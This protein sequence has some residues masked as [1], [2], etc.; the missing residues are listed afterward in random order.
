[1]KVGSRYSPLTTNS[2]CKLPKAT[3]L[4]E[5]PHSNNGGEESTDSVCGKNDIHNLPGGSVA[6]GNPCIPDLPV[7]VEMLLA[8]T[9]QLTCQAYVLVG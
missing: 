3:G 2:V 8:G 4:R 9:R 6:K 1:M 7:C 5:K